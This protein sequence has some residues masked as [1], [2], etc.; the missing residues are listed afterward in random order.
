MKRIFK[1]LAVLLLAVGLYQ[2]GLQSGRQ[3]ASICSAYFVVLDARDKTPIKPYALQGP[4][5]RSE[6]PG[7]VFYMNE[8]TGFFAAVS[9]Y[10][11]AICISA[12]GYQTNEVILEP[13]HGYLFNLN[14]PG[15][16]LLKRLP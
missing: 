2:C 6:T 9:Q 16:I 10:P 4:E 13:H 8:A 1:V 15:E 12:K 3:R 14:P 5:H 11:V 7:E